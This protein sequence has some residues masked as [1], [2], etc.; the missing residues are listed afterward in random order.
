MSDST[1]GIPDRD[2]IERGIDSEQDLLTGADDSP[3]VFEGSSEDEPD[4]ESVI[5]HD[6]PSVFRT[7]VA[8]QRLTDDELE[9][10]LD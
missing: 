8:G 6:K 10:D 2:D 9:K 4:L 5:D 1:P 7:P 3:D